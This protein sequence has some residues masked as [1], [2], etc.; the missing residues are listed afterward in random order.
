ME[1]PLAWVARRGIRLY[2]SQVLGAEETLAR[3][4]TSSRRRAAKPASAA[5]RRT[6]RTDGD[7]GQLRGFEEPLTEGPQIFLQDT[8][9]GRLGLAATALVSLGIG[10]VTKRHHL[11][12]SRYEPTTMSGP[13]P[14]QVTPQP[15]K[16]PHAT[17][18]VWGADQMLAGLIVE[19]LSQ[20]PVRRM[21]QPVLGNCLMWTSDC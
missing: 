10:S 16:G 2:I 19:L 12:L 4:T 1:R 5:R 6:M 11:P 15:I 3:V 20:A 8:R 9:D 13:T 18:G 17:E 21:I 7:A 14:L